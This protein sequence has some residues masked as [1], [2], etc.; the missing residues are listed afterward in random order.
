MQAALRGKCY[1]TPQI[2]RG[3]QESFIRNPHGTSSPRP[4]KVLKITPRAVAFHKYRTM[5]ALGL[6]TNAELV[7][8]VI[9]DRIALA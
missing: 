6:K 1:I 3:M 7:Q 2:A 4:A 8:F 5:R 9:R